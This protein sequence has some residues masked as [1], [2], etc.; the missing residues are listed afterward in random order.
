MYTAR[1]NFRDPA[2]GSTLNREIPYGQHEHG[3]CLYQTRYA[4]ISECTFFGY[5]RMQT[6]GGRIGEKNRRVLNTF[7]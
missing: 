5:E 6:D 2:R 1:H 3:Q 7:S 4:I